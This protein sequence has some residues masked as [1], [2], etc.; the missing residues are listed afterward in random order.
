MGLFKRQM[1]VRRHSYKRAQEKALRITDYTR[2]WWGRSPSAPE[3]GS[4]VP[5]QRS[6]HRAPSWV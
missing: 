6:G 3:L 4:W 5:G 1:D 2:G